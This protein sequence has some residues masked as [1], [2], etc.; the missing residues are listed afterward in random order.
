MTK[1]RTYL[2]PLAWLLVGL[3][4]ILIAVWGVNLARTALSLRAHLAQAQ[5]LAAAPADADPHAT[6]ALVRDLRQDVVDLN[7]QAGALARIGPALGWLPRVGGNARAAPHLLVVADGLT[8]AGAIG[9]DTLAPALARS[10]DPLSLPQLGQLLVEHR[11]QLEQALAGVERAQV[12]WAQ[13]D[14]DALS[15]WLA[16]KAAPLERGLPLLHA[17]LSAAVVGPELLGMDRPR[18]YLVLALNEDEL[19]PLAGFITGVGE[20]RV[21]GGRVVDMTFRDSYAVDD[22]S[23]PYPDAPEPLQ[24]YMGIDLWVFHDA[25]WSPDFPTTARQAVALYRPGHPVTID[26][27]I[28]LDQQ[29]VQGLVAAL[30]PLALPDVPQPVTGETVIPYM[31]GAWSPDDQ[32]LSMEWFRQRKSF[33]EPLAAA[34]WERVSSGRVDRSSLATALL[35]LLEEKHLLIYLE[36]PPQAAGLLAAQGWD[37]ALP[38]QAGDFLMVVDAN[39]GYNKASVRVEESIAYTVDLGAT[40]PRATL[41]LAYTHTGDVDYPCIPEVR[42][43]PVY[44]DMMDRCYWDYLRVYVPQGS[45]LLDATRIPVPGDALRSGEGETGE[46]AVLTAAEGDFLTWAVLGVL[47]PGASHMRHFTWTLPPDIVQA[48]GDASLYVLHVPKQAG[49]PARPLEVRVRLPQGASLLQASPEP[50][51]VEDGVVIYHTV[52]DGDRM[53]RVRFAGQED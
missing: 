42:Y 18:T 30:G 50:A 6:C 22:F 53:F 45:R 48:Q 52:L 5:D 2:K 14:R 19:R 28:A 1:N 29:A 3:G 24:R 20:V 44:E 43:D 32:V 25:T 26:G 46:V 17:G 7:R 10:G 34:A 47:P 16:G 15:P 39:V 12:A 35:Q 23:R 49:T 31:R 8:E 41:T 36:Q 11:A 13:V 40:E 4:L 27:V 37:G 38:R 33:M 9:C 51:A 21:E